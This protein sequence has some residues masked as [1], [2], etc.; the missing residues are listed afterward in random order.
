MRINTKKMIADVLTCARCSEDHKGLLFLQLQT[1]IRDLTHWSIC[2]VT[3]EPILLR[4]EEEKSLKDY[5]D[6][7]EGTAHEIWSASQLLP[8]EGIEDGVDR[9]KNILL[10]WKHGFLANS[11]YSL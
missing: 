5:D 6:D 4:V 10:E 7:L 1:P 11:G 3:N 9:I 2:P 8:H